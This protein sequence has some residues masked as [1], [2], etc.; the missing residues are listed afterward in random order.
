MANSRSAPARPL[1]PHLQIYKPMINMVMSIMH[2]ITGVALYLGTILLA[3]F[4]TA[5]AL[6]PDYYG[7]VIGLAGTP[8]G[9]LVLLG[10]TWA[11]LHHMVGGIRHFIWDTGRGFELSTVNNLSWLT[12]ILSLSLTVG[13][14]LFG[15]L[16]LQG[17]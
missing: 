9:L 8:I 3:W 6:G 4:L 13:V 16:T 15:Y 1:S 7:F 17:A 11:F 12:I 2:R 10:Y 5:V 14:W